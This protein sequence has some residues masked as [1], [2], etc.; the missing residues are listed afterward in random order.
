MDDL[1]LAK[2]IEKRDYRMIIYLIPPVAIKLAL[3][4]NNMSREKIAII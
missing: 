4:G 3:R 2:A 1:Y